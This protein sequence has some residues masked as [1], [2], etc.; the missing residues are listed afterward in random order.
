MIDEYAREIIACRSVYQC[1]CHRAVHAARKSAQYLFISDF[2][3]ERAD[4]VSHEITHR[5]I[6]RG[7]ANLVQEILDNLAAL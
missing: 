1:S 5:P 2:F 6:A 7:V 3:L 4:L